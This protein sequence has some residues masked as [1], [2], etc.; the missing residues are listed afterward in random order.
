MESAYI[1]IIVFLLSFL[2]IVSLTWMLAMFIA[3]KLFLSSKEVSSF[4]SFPMD[5]PQEKYSA[6]FVNSIFLTPSISH[7]LNKIEQEEFDEFYQRLL[8]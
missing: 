3:R 2:V 7:K 1:T 4:I 5:I 8:K 6:F